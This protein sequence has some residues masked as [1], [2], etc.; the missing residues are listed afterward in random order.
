M[1]SVVP[2]WFVFSFIP[3]DLFYL[4]YLLPISCI[5]NKYGCVTFLQLQDAANASERHFMACDNLINAAGPWAGDLAQTIG[6]DLP[7]RPKK[8]YVFVFHCPEGPKDMVLA[9]DTSGCWFRREGAGDLY[10]CGK[11]PDKVNSLQQL[12]IC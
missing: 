3:V 8:R 10:L 9:V 11:C 2:I 5:P 7:V 1:I 12:M 6:V 4:V